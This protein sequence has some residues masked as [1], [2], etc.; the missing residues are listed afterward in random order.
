MKNNLSKNW[1]RK[2]ID[3]QFLFLSKKKLFDNL[4]TLKFEKNELGNF[5]FGIS[6]SKKKYKRAV[7]RNKI[8]RQIKSI[9]QKIDFNKSYDVVILVKNNYLENSYLTKEEKLINLLRKIR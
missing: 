6:I 7:D 8:K 4:Y 2:N 9:L 5:R 3:F 1:I